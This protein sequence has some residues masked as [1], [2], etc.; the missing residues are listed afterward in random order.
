MKRKHITD[1]PL[2]WCGPKLEKP[3]QICLGEDDGGL[4]L[5]CWRCHGL[6]M[7]A[8]G[9]RD[10]NPLVIHRDL[11]IDEEGEISPVGSGPGAL[12]FLV[13]ILIVI[14]IAVVYLAMANHAPG[15]TR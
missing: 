9:P 13:L 10:S 8:A 6:G 2:C 5:P 4:A 11:D 15:G 12:T 3:C 7:V 1:S 14:L